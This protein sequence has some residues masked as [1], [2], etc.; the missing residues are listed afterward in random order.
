MS[1]KQINFALF[2][3]KK[4]KKYSFHATFVISINFMTSDIVLASLLLLLILSFVNQCVCVCVCGQEE[5]N[6]ITYSTILFDDLD[7]FIFPRGIQYMH[8]C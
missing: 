5:V 3:D 4:Y 7:T 8:A 6:S 1:V 2:T